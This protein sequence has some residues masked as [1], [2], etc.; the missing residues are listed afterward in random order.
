MIAVID[1]H[2]SPNLLPVLLYLVG[3][4]MGA[5]VYAV[6]D[7]HRLGYMQEGLALIIKGTLPSDMAPKKVEYRRP[8]RAM[9]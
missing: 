1:T 7:A 3:D 6:N 2:N 9:E 5:S 4:I 8:N